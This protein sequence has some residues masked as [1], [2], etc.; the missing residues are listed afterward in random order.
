M[1]KYLITILTLALLSAC[2]KD[3][4][5]YLFGEYLTPEQAL[6]SDINI[7][8]SEQFVYE[9]TEPTE[10]EGF[11]LNIQTIDNYPCCNY[12][13][14]RTVIQEGSTLII[15][16]EDVIKPSICL[17]AIGPATTTVKVPEGISRIVFLRGEDEDYFDFDVTNKEM[18]LY[19]VSASFSTS[20]FI[21]YYRRPKN[22]FAFICGTT[23]DTQYIYHA[24]LEELKKISSVKELTFGEGLL[25]WPESTNGYWVDFPTR[26]FTYDKPEDFVKVYELFCRFAQRELKNKQ[27]VGLSLY[28]WNDICYN[29]WEV[30]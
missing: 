3:N 20:D 1:K 11:F 12:G 17:T 19:P 5:E 8:I 27:G 15:R 22:S 9:K 13:I 23:E 10:D 4:A 25:P 7:S 21:T 28:D 26:F 16:L 29:S 6:L 30:Q 14:Q 2:S 18:N 24:F